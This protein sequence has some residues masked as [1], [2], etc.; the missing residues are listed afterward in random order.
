MFLLFGLKR[1]DVLAVGDAGLQRAARTLYG[2]RRRKS[3]TL[4]AQV[5]ENWRPYR[6]I[7]SWYLWR[8]LEA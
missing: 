8:S 2:K 6:S 5:G 1:L 4:L 3:E 7:A